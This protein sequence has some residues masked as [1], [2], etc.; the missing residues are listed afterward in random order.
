M[1]RNIYNDLLV[2]KSSAN[3]KP[4]LLLGARQVGK[5]WIMR[6]FGKQEYKNVAYVNCDDEVRM[7]HLFESDYDIERILL[8]LQAITGVKIEEGNTLIILDEIQEIARGLHS[9][10]YFC[11]KAPGYHVMVAGSL[12]GV[13]IG[14]GESFPVGKVDMLQMLSLIHISEPTRRP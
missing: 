2:W 8:A 5:T 13:T 4:L 6:H 9:L 3:R 12:L 7:K 1:R 14:K 10:K 11:E